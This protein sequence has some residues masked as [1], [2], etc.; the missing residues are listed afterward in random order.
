MCDG[1]VKLKVCLQV[2]GLARALAMS[3]MLVMTVL[4]P[5]PLPSTLAARRGILYR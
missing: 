4:T 1:E 3:D 5:L 2:G